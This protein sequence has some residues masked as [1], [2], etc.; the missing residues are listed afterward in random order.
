MSTYE[1]KLIEERDA[2]LD[3]LK[4]CNND[5]ETYDKTLARIQDIDDLYQ[6]AFNNNLERQKLDVDIQRIESEL[7]ASRRLLWGNVLKVGGDILKAAI[8]V[9]AFGGF[10]AETQKYE[11]DNVYSSTSSKAIIRKGTDFLKF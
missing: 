1:E 9:V 5:S 6:H 2:L 3:R 10:M 11:Q 8:G 7:K 4:L